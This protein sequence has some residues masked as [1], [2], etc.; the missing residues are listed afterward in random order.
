[1]VGS[2]VSKG[3]KYAIPP[4]ANRTYPLLRIHGSWLKTYRSVLPKGG[5]PDSKYVVFVACCVGT[6]LWYL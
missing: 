6:V 1:M 3:A 4:Y 2:S 5:I